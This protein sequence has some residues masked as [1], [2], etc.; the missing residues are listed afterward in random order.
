[1]VEHAADFEWRG[2]GEEAEVAVYAPDAADADRAFERA[3]PAARLP[4]VESPVEA[5]ASRE[6]FGRVAVSGTHAAPDLFSA[7]RWGL[8]IVAEVPASSLGMPPEEVPR[9]LSRRLSEVALPEI[10]EPGVRELSESG[11]LWAAGEGFIEEDDLSFFSPGSAS[12]AGDPDSLG[13]RALAA[14]A[15]DWTRPGGVEALAVG[16]ILDSDAA[17][18]AGLE[19][20]TLALVVGVGAEDLGRLA[21]AGHRERIVAKTI[22]GDFGAPRA[23][24]PPRWTRRRR[25]TSDRR[26][27]RGGLRRRTRRPRPLRA[28]PL[29]QGPDAPAP[30]C[31]MAV[32]GLEGEDGGRHVHRDGLAAV[33]EGGLFV[34]GLHVATGKGR[35]FVSAPPFGVPA[36]GDGG[37]GK[38]PVCARACRYWSPSGGG[39]RRGRGPL[40]GTRKIQRPVRLRRDAR[41]PPR[42]D[43]L[44]V[45]PA[46]RAPGGPGP[47]L[48]RRRDVGGDRRVGDGLGG[49]V[50]QGLPRVRAA[51]RARG[52]ERI[53][54][55]EPVTGEVLDKFSGLISTALGLVAALAWNTAIQNLFTTIFGEAGG[56]LVGQFLYAILITVVVIFAT[57]AVSRAAERAKKLEEEQKGLLGKLKE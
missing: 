19:E 31:G 20:G 34:S 26:P 54:G 8:L 12:R 4:G 2:E 56:A 29:L 36:D 17:G 1:M 15:R 6:G 57:I 3:L 38:R 39:R 44:G 14:G 55:E 22:H 35:M 33:G 24:P 13:R 47:G 50:H 32:G 16:E 37:P 41:A 52:R 9:L 48:L 40:D 45:R 5:A 18:E 11:A 30:P 7:P 28:A 10:G 23:S 53:E 42:G 46:Q 43:A 25:R 49:G 51:G 27:G 21:L